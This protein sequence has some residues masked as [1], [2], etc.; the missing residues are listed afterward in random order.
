MVAFPP[1]LSFLLQGVSSTNDMLVSIL[2]VL[3]KNRANK[4]APLILLQTRFSF[5]K[6]HH[7][8]CFVFT[9]SNWIWHLK[10]DE[11]R[12]EIN[13]LVAD[14]WIAS[15]SKSCTWTQRKDSSWCQLAHK[16]WVSENNTPCHQVGIVCFHHSKSL[17]QTVNTQMVIMTKQRYVVPLLLIRLPLIVNIGTFRFELGSLNLNSPQDWTEKRQIAESLHCTAKSNSIDVT[18]SQVQPC[19]IILIHLSTKYVTRMQ[20]TPQRLGPHMLT[21]SPLLAEHQTSASAVFLSP[22]L[23]HHATSTMDLL[24]SRA[25]LSPRWRVTAASNPLKAPVSTWKR[26]STNVCVGNPRERCFLKSMA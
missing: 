5:I 3:N 14:C 10:I 2:A 8:K 7:R 24:H 22:V 15:Q 21:S 11:H 4:V 13:E 12:I 1:K 25:R 16:F 23:L 9:S 26:Y 20:E 6:Q 18:L 17:W 19:R